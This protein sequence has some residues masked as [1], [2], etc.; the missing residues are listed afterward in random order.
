MSVTVNMAASLA[1][2]F[3]ETVEQPHFQLRSFRI[4]KKI[5]ATLDQEKDTMMVK[6]PLKEQSVFCGYDKSIFYPVPGGWGLK[7]ATYVDLKKVRKPMLKDALTV[8]Y[9]AIAP[10]DL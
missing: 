3:P 9:C 5:Y 1:L 4:R 10:V 7:G 8:A 2:S 6:L